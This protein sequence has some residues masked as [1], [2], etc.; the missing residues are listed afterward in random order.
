MKRNTAQLLYLRDQFF[1]KLAANTPL[2]YNR[3]NET[4]LE[5]WLSDYNVPYSKPADRKDLENL[6]K[7]NWQSKIVAPYRDRKSVV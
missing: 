5:R 3:W 4:E 1:S 6:V 2:V 7:K